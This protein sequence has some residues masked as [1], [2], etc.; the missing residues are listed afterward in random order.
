M[1]FF[2]VTQGQICDGQEVS[3]QTDR[4][5][6]RSQVPAETPAERRPAT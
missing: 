6:V 2:F 5:T 3:R 1:I 4:Q